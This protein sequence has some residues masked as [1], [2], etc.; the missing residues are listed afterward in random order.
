V[1]ALKLEH[2]SLAWLPEP[3]VWFQLQD[4]VTD[5]SHSKLLISVRV[6]DVGLGN[7]R[8]NILG[9]SY[10]VCPVCLDQGEMC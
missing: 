10:K 7:R 3:R 9:H 6:G 2:T 4:H 8:L 5:D 1:R